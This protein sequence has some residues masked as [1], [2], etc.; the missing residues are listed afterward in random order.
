MGFFYRPEYRT[1]DG[2][3][4]K[5]EVFVGRIV[6]TIV[7]GLVLLVSAGMSGCP[8][9]GVWAQGLKGQAELARAEQNRQIKIQEAQAIMESATMLAE[10]EVARAHG[11]AQAN[12]IVA[13]GLGGPEGYL[14]YLWIQHL[15]DQSSKVIYVPTEG[16]IPIMEA[17]RTPMPVPKSK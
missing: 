15:A 9:Y 16:Q 2:D 8:R 12:E 1:G 5:E 11:V 4:V 13:E 3:R 14:R 17:G 7:L 10:A 6:G